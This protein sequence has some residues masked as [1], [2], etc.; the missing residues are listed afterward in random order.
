MCAWE[1]KCMKHLK[2]G[3]QQNLKSPKLS[4][5]SSGSIF[6]NRNFWKPKTVMKVHDFFLKF[7]S[8]LKWSRW[9]TLH[10]ES[11]NFTLIRTVN[12]SVV[13]FNTHSAANAE[14]QLT[15]A[16]SVSSHRRGYHGD[17]SFAFPLCFFHTWHVFMWQVYHDKMSPL[18]QIIWCLL[19]PVP[20]R[21]FL[22]PHLV[23]NTLSEDLKWPFVS[24][25]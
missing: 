6:K 15:Q 14:R 23:P 5:Y 22:N 3:T 12:C 1:G 24:L 9:P 10:V 2:H 16:P 13:S 21:G 8:F 11:T 19:D 17:D 25:C 20:S 7:Q 18:I 4:L